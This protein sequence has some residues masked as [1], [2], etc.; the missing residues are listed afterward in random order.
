MST[1]LLLGFHC[2]LRTGELLALSPADFFLGETQGIFSLKSTKSGKRHAASE[3]ITDPS[4][5]KACGLFCLPSMGLN[6]DA[7]PRWTGNGA[8]FRKRF[9]ALCQVFDL[10]RHAFRPYSLSRG[11]ATELFQRTQSM[12]AAL[13]RGRWESPRVACIYIS[14]RLSFLPGLVL[15]NRTQSLLQ[16]RY[17][18]DPRRG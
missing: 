6:I 10:E 9:A 5:W 15:S 7:L 13:I 11:G 16:S 18:L 14:D 17:F 4:P 3:A 12:E 8:A 2:L 1:L